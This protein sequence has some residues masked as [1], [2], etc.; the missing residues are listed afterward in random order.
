M[1]TLAG[2]VELPA[3][4]RAFNAI[5]LQL[6]G[7]ECATP[8]NTNI[9]ET[10]RDACRITKQGEIMAERPDHDRLVRKFASQCHGI[11]EIYIHA[12]CLFSRF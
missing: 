11:P 5:A 12:L 1:H 4:I 10:M 6:A 7:T 9:R 8:V 3:M 2:R